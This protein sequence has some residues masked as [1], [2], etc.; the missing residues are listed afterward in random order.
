VG[1]A[2]ATA[3][4]APDW[5]VLAPWS[6][7]AASDLEVIETGAWLA[8]E[9]ETEAMDVLETAL[10]AFRPV[11]ELVPE[12]A[13]VLPLDDGRPA[14]GVAARATLTP[15]LALA[16]PESWTL[17]VCSLSTD[18]VPLPP[19]AVPALSWVLV[20]VVIAPPAKALLEPLRAVVADSGVGERVGA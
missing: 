3:Q 7:T 19:A 4:A 14:F 12:F 18:S 10:E 17:L 15:D 13:R 20:V 5:A 1:L 2:A 9:T 11:A 16:A 8:P 6:V